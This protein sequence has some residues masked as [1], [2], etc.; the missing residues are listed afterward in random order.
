MSFLDRFRRKKEDET[1]RFARLAKTGRIVEGSVI[2]VRSNDHER[3]THVFYRYDIAGVDYESS[4]ELND[5]QKTR[6]AS[7]APGARIIIRYDPRQP[8]NSIVV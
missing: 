2:D 8:G 3:I 5:E 7:Y 6:E 4:Q 1:A